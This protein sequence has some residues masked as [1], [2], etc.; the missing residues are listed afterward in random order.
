MFWKRKDVEPSEFFAGMAESQFERVLEAAVEVEE[1]LHKANSWDQLGSL[2][3]LDHRPVIPE[4]FRMEF[5]DL[6]VLIGSRSHNR[7]AQAAFMVFEGFLEGLPGVDG[8][9]EHRSVLGVTAKGRPF[10]FTR[11]RDENGLD[12]IDRFGLLLDANPLHQK[13]FFFV[14]SYF[15]PV[16]TGAVPPPSVFAQRRALSQVAVHRVMTMVTDGEEV[17]PGA[18]T[19][20][21]VVPDS[22]EAAA[23]VDSILG[24]PGNGVSL[25]HRSPLEVEVTSDT[26]WADLR[27]ELEESVD[28]DQ[29]ELINWADGFL[30][31]HLVFPTTPGWFAA[32]S[33]AL[34]S[35]RV[36]RVTTFL[37]EGGLG[38]W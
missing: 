17:F 7:D 28:E 9:R 23:R 6:D 11:F 25:A 20:R 21:L 30:L 27:N 24:W 12:H 13:L 31:G 34:D 18:T 4:G 36:D 33:R 10:S 26:S 5:G 32:L 3:E 1:F 29:Y 16:I 38:E 8:P 14:R 19:E 22:E 35:A 37:A 2:W 15:S